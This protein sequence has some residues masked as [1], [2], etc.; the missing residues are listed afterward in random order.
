MKK[1]K[2]AKIWKCQNEYECRY[3]VTT[4]TRLTYSLTRTVHAIIIQCQCA[5]KRL[6][7]YVSGFVYAYVY[8]IIAVRQSVVWWRTTQKKKKKWREREKNEH[9]NSKS[10]YVRNLTRYRAVGRS[11]REGISWRVKSL[12]D[13]HCRGRLCIAVVMDPRNPMKYSAAAVYNARI[14]DVDR[15]RLA[16]VGSKRYYTGKQL[17]R[18]NLNSVF[19]PVWEFLRRR[20]VISSG[21]R[22]FP[23]PRLHPPPARMAGEHIRICV[24]VRLP[25]VGNLFIYF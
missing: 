14:T 17:S 8:Q 11:R 1:K 4:W 22:R 19:V 7:F 18:S 20:V 24:G 16:A 25:A 10:R 13:T 2:T 9:R 23:V 12:S 6:N 21:I 5:W 15:W 3:N